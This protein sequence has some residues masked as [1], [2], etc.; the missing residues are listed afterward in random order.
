MVGQ[1]VEL[2]LLFVIIGC[3]FSALIAFIWVA[4]RLGPKGRANHGGGG[5]NG[6]IFTD[7]YR[8]HLVEKG[9]ARFE[10]TLDQNAAF[11][12]QDLHT[13][14]DE[15]TEYIKD[16]AGEIL[17]EEFS[18][19]KQAI[20]AA[21]QHMAEAFSRIDKTMA[22]YQKN[23]TDQFAHELAEEK[24]R[25]IE[26]FNANMADVITHHVQY[27]L[28]THLEV[29]DQVKYILSHLDENKQAIIEDMKR[30]V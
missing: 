25:R 8:Q 21:Q 14:S 7:E 13:I 22:D 5:G 29:T 20:T 16:K 26:H 17:K 1:N 24:Q 12:Q 11:L 30:E 2:I 3:I 23:L 28:A 6:D 18:D 19:Q 15:V 27:S 10:R 4:L 9:T